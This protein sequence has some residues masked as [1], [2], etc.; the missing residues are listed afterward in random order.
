MSVNLKSQLCHESTFA[1]AGNRDFSKQQLL[2]YTGVSECK[3]DCIHRD[4]K[5]LN[6]WLRRHMYCYGDS[7]DSTEI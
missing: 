5:I 2:S 3:T 7:L 1:H 6:K 4:N